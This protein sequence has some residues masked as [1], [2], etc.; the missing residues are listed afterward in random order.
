MSTL[1][2]PNEY[3]VAFDSSNIPATS[4]AW[5]LT[6]PNATVWTPSISTAGIVSVT[7]SGTAGD[8]V[9]FVGLDGN[10]WT[11][12]ISNGGIVTATSGGALSSSDTIATLD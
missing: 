3:R 12:T 7:D 9:V 2:R 10:K 1:V 11:P 4:S 8:S 6:S 5:T